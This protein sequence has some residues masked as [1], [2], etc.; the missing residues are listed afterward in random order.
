MLLAAS[1]I[2]PSFL[3]GGVLDLPYVPPSPDTKPEFLLGSRLPKT[4]PPGLASPAPS[5]PAL[6]ASTMPSPTISFDAMDFAT[7]GAGHPPDTNGDVGADYFMEGVNT[8]IGIY[9]KTTGA[10]ASSFTFN[11]FWLGAAT[12]TACDNSNQGDPIVLYDAIRQHWIFMDFAWT[13]IQDGPYF[14]CFGVS[15]T[16]DPLG[17]YVRY[18]VRADDDA[19]PWLPDYP[20]GGIW[21]DAMYFSANMFDCLN[22]N[23]SFSASKEARLRL[24][25]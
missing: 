10:L 13:N 7:N 5:A 16:S 20:K 3:R 11:S 18:A 22:S 25:Y 8:T 9:T 4:P 1:P 2:Q 24:Q 12:G 14:Y 19:H 15:L 21:P 17:D 23:C 6:V